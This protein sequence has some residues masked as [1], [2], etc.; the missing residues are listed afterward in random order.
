MLHDR[1]QFI[2]AAL[3]ALFLVCKSMGFRVGGAWRKKKFSPPPSKMYHTNLFVRTR[4]VSRCYY[5]V[6][7]NMIKILL[8]AGSLFQGT[9]FFHVLF[10][11]REQGKIHWT[12]DPRPVVLVSG[13]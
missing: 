6:A 11:K 12:A 7:G 8:L 4:I 13:Q 10:H 5:S 2:P 3:Y 9:L 1:S